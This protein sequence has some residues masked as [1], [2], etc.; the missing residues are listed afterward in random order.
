MPRR[1]WQGP[2]RDLW[3]SPPPLPPS[4]PPPS[5]PPPFAPPPPPLSTRSPFYPPPLAPP[6]PPSLAPRMPADNDA[7]HLLRFTYSPGNS[8]MRRRNLNAIGLA[9]RNELPP[10]IHELPPLR[11]QI[12]VSITPFNGNAGGMGKRLFHDQYICCPPLIDSV[13][14]V[15]KSASSAVRNTTPRAMSWA[16]PSRPMGMRAMIFASTSGGTAR[17][18]SVST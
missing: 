9:S 12:A 7:P 4:T 10:R 15:M 17:T 13:E 1:P 16:M 8:R 14:P 3:P 5:Y 6:A 18:M 2:W 11:H